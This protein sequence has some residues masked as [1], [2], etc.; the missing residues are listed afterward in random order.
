MRHKSRRV[1]IHSIRE[2]DLRIWE[3]QAD[4]DSKILEKQCGV[5]ETASPQGASLSDIR[6][7]CGSLEQSRVCEANWTWKRW[8]HETSKRGHKRHWTFSCLGPLAHLLWGKLVTMLWGLWRTRGEAHT[9]M[10]WGLSPIS[11]PTGQPHEWAHLY[12]EPPAPVKLADECTTNS[13]P[14][15]SWAA[16]SQNTPAKPILNAWLWET[17]EDNK[18]SMLF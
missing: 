15:T 11:A 3:G 1:F 18:C 4:R 10:N 5:K 9:V 7:S 16:S 6:A 17:I 14:A 12:V 8:Q 2:P 13:I